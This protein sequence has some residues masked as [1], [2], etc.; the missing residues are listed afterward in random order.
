MRGWRVRRQ[1]G[2]RMSARIVVSSLFVSI[3]ALR[4]LVVGAEAAEKAPVLDMFADGEVQIAVDGSVSDYRLNSQL[5]AQVAALVDRNVRLGHFE[6]IVIDGKGVVA[7]TA[8]HLSLRAEPSGE[9]DHYRIKVTAVRFGGPRQHDQTHKPHYPDAAIAMRLGAKVVLAL[10]LDDQGR[11][12][13]VEPLQT[14]L[15]ARANSEAEA[16]T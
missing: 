15:D 14:S 8:M 1:P 12:I 2:G 3:L 9:A 5:P 10:Q 4:G 16:E 7:K 11:V 6:P 13:E